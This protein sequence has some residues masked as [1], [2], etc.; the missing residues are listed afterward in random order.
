MSGNVIRKPIIFYNKIIKMKETYLMK[1]CPTWTV[2]WMKATWGMYAWVCKHVCAC[3]WVWCTSKPNHN[4]Y[5]RHKMILP[6]VLSCDSL[7]LPQNTN[8]K[9]ETTLFWKLIY[10]CIREI[11]HCMRTLPEC[12]RVPSDK[13]LLYSF[14]LLKQW[15][16]CAIL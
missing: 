15:N 10:V 6:K 8:C 12:I 9:R 4:N 1:Y 2:C 14:Q 3:V 11:K 13:Y 16:T 5:R 7:M